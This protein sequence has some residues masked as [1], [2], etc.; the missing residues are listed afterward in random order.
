MTTLRV[1]VR[2][3]ASLGTSTPP[4]ARACAEDQRGE[5]ARL[6]PRAG[7]SSSMRARTVRV[8]A[9]TSGRMRA[10]AA[11][12]HRVRDTP[13]PAPRRARPASPSDACASGTSAFTQTVERSTMRKSVVP[14]GHR[15][16]LAHAELGDHAAR[17]ATC[18]VKRVR[19]ACRR[20]RRAAICASLMPSSSKRWRAACASA[21]S[22]AR[23]L[24]RSSRYSSCA[25]AQS[26][27]QDLDER[28]A[29]ASPDRAARARAASRRSPRRAPAAA[30]R[31]ARCRP[32][33]RS[34]R[35]AA[36][37]RRC[38]A[39]AVRTPRFCTMRGLIDTVP[40]SA[41]PRRRTSARAACP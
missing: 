33:S 30:P 17:S 13:A 18:S 6:E 28:R 40:A 38:V 26:G 31:R 3:T 10:D 7:L 37:S 32:P 23:S 16:A 14:G 41:A 34:P 2:I 12:E 19:A 21:V 4:C 5:H 29:L 35:S 25:P 15:H 24:R 39:S 27:K 11:V 36:R 1:P 22:S 9:L 8:A 20:A